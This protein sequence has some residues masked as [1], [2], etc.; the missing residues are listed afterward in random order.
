MQSEAL[1]LIVNG[2]YFCGCGEN[3]GFVFSVNL[4]DAIFYGLSSDALTARAKTLRE[5]GYKVEL[6]RLAVSPS[7][8][9]SD[10]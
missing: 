8:S 9:V 2:L 6:A 5:L 3:V 10:L 1:L 4:K 7:E